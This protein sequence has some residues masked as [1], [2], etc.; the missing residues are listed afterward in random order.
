MAPPT[1]APALEFKVVH[2]RAGHEDAPATH[3]TGQFVHAI[4][5]VIEVGM[6]GRVL[7]APPQYGVWIPPGLE[8]VSSNRHEARYATLYVPPPWC[9]ELPAQACTLAVNPLMLALLD[10]LRE[11]MTAWLHTAKAQRL[12]W[13]LLDQL[14]EAPP[15]DSYL[16]MSQD[17]LLAQ[18]L[19]ALQAQ[20]W[21]TRSLADWASSVHTTERTLARRCQRDLNMSFNEWRQRL[22]VLKG[23][24][25][26]E[27]G[28]AVK[29]V[30]MDLGYSAPSAFISM[31]QRQVGLTPQA[32][33]Q[34][35]RGSR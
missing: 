33:M 35:K 15:H 26:L 30:A 34:H 1:P 27:A 21:D 23:I 3:D 2:V 29:R 14:T 32:Y 22:K 9:A 4:S 24:A 7:L 5:G 6:A 18:V 13:V 16:P 19:H 28:H 11:G 17:P 31:F 12:L 25:L 8:H 20:P 10:T